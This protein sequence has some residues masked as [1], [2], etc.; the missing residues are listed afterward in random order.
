MYQYET[1]NWHNGAPIWGNAESITDAIDMM[2]DSM[3]IHPSLEYVT[4]HIGDRLHIYIGN[5][6]TEDYI[7]FVYPVVRGGL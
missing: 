1:Y 3:H 6:N 5:I 4:R 2:Y 7:G